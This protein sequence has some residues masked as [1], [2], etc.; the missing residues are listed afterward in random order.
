[1]SDNSNATNRIGSI[2]L[3]NL[4]STLL[5]VFSFAEKYDEKKLKMKVWWSRTIFVDL[6]KILLILP[7]KSTSL[8]QSGS[9]SQQSRRRRAC[10]LV[11]GLFRGR[12]AYAGP[13]KGLGVWRIMHRLMVLV[14]RVTKNA[15]AAPSCNAGHRHSDDQVRPIATQPPDQTARDQDAGVRDEIVQAKRVG[16]PC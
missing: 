15:N 5:R 6:Q 16:R 13:S 7:Q 1:M 4:Y 8:Y 2:N 14:V 9:D 12:G 3:R 10:H 11:Q